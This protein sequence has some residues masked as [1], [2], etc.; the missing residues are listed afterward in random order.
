M[1][2]KILNPNVY[3]GTYDTMGA[4]EFRPLPELPGS[5]EHSKLMKQ[6]IREIP[7]GLSA[8]DHKKA[9]CESMAGC[10]SSADYATHFERPEY[11]ETEAANKR[12]A[13]HNTEKRERAAA[14][15]RGENINMRRDKCAG[16]P[17]M[18]A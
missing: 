7:E 6:R 14:I 4:K 17:N 16:D 13:E 18:T 5:E 9:M 15:K 2:E 12:I 1:G 11:K 8:K 10:P 3:G